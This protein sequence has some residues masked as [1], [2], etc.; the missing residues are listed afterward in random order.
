M[1]RDAASNQG[2]D[3]G[4]V[5]VH[6]QEITIERRGSIRTAQQFAQGVV[7]KDGWFA[8]CGVPVA[9]QVAGLGIHGTDSTGLVPVSL[10]AD[11]FGRRDFFIGGTGVL[12]GSVRKEKGGP[13][14]NARVALAGGERVAITDSGGVFRFG[15]IPAGSQ[16]VHVRALG[17]AEELRPML[18]TAGSDTSITFTLTEVKRVLDT[19]RVVAQRVYDR[20]SHGFLRRKKVGGGRFFDEET[21]A[22]MRPIDLS[23]LLYG[24]P[25]ITQ[26]Y[27]GFKRL[28]LM[29]S[30]SGGEYCMPTLYLNG[31]RMPADLLSDL[32]ILVRPEELA[33]MEVY[34]AGTAPPQFADFRSGCGAIVIWTRPP[35]PRPS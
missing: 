33:G 32:D 5:Q 12:R 18:V 11:G 24:I 35:R 30:T 6:W 25:S 23:Q 28:W 16:T 8:I 3:T 31:A 7:G 13:I 10:P 19:I 26:R 34:R 20:D 4:I 15:A 29:R 21:I 2:V 22:R 14:V 17:Y 1:L 9:T 27:S